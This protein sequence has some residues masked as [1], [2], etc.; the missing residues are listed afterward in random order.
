MYTLFQIIIL[1][2][3]STIG[4]PELKTQKQKRYE[5]DAQTIEN[6]AETIEKRGGTIEHSAK[7]IETGDET[8]ETAPKRSI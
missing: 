2:E 6:G 4:R 8:I 5:N 3:A 1:T 7:T